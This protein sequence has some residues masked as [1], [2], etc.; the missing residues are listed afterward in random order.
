MTTRQR[1]GTAKSTT[2]LDA[3]APA[4]DYTVS[5]YTISRDERHALFCVA[6]Q[7]NH[8]LEIVKKSVGLSPEQIAD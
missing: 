7:A 8:N 4:F 6:T 5:L 2:Q 1:G 3:V